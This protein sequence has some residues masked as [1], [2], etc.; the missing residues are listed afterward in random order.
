MNEGRKASK[1]GAGRE[2]AY[3]GQVPRIGDDVK[4]LRGWLLTN[5]ALL[6][7]LLYNY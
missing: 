7:R 3:V 6:T 4:E 1:V 5:T 2:P